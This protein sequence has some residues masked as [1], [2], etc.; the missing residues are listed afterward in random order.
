MSH[1][2]V[3][4]RIGIETLI[5]CGELTMASF[6]RLLCLGL[7]TGFS[8]PAFALDD[9]PQNRAQEAA[10]YMEAVPPEGSATDMLQAIA[11]NLPEPQQK[12]FLA[13]MQKNIDM[14][15]I[16]TASQAALVKVFTADEL[17][18][19]ADFYGAPLAKSAMG[20]MGAYIA[21]VMPTIEKAV[22][23]AAEKAEKDTGVKLDTKQGQ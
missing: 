12:T 11:Q 15:G 18:A 2:A 7:L 22:D 10:R 16:K 6:V 17:K 20:K 4:A 13:A 5:L 9:T 19:L 3:Q 8:V 1:A 21:E 14:S 23:A